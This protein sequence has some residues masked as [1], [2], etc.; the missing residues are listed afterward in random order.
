[1][2]LG[3]YWVKTDL[4]LFWLKKIEENGKDLK[5]AEKT[6]IAIALFLMFAMTISIVAIPA[7]NAQTTRKTYAYI[8]ALPN[9]VGVNQ[10]VLLHIG[11]TQ[12]LSLADMGWEGLSVTIER[13]DGKTDKI[14]NIR[15]DSTGGTGR[16]YTPPIEGNYTLQTHFP[17]QKT[18]A[19]KSAP[20]VAEGTTML[21]SSSAKLTLVV[22]EEPVPI[23]PKHALPTEYWSRPID[24][25]LREWSVVAGNWPAPIS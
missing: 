7:T 6:S 20:G 1:M 21:A 5:F 9:P 15:T 16:T 12:E 22:Q 10:E 24:A 11:I 17:E 25:Q 23:Y 19:T 3:G 8:G 18:T 4:G 13:P 14:E 2:Q